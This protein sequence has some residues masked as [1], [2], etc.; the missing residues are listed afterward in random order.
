MRDGLC[1][2][3]RR[4]L[5]LQITP[6]SKFSTTLH[7]SS[8]QKPDTVRKFGFLLQLGFPVGIMRSNFIREKPH[9]GTPRAYAWHRAA[10]IGDGQNLEAVPLSLT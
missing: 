9:D 8:I 1:D 4:R 2:N 6:R 5:V 7:H 3:G 10:K